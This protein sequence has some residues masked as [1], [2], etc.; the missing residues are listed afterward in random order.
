MQAT[1]QADG[2]D[3]PAAIRGVACRPHAS[4]LYRRGTLELPTRPTPVE[5]IRSKIAEVPGA[6]GPPCWVY[7][8]SLSEGYGRTKINGRRWLV[9]RYVWEH[10]YGPIADGLEL[11]H[12]CRN[13]ACCNP[14]HLEPVT[15]VVNQRRSF[16][17]WG[18]NARKTHC[19]HGHE[20]TAA[21]TIPIKGGRACRACRRETQARARRAQRR[22]EAS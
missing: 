5:R 20:F 8:G 16:S 4:R 3:R 15:P 14:A 22:E 10:T 6:F 21:N 12:L 17:P 11:D 13:R 19:I 1:C 9:H 18:I 7:T 2:C